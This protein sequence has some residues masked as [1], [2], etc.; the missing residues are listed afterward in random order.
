ME[1]LIKGAAYIIPLYVILVLVAAHRKKVDAY[2]I[3]VSGAGEGIA[4]AFKVMPYMA[5]MLFAIAML[6]ASGAADW[7]GGGADRLLHLLGVPE[8]I[9]LFLLLR[10]L[11]GSAALAELSEIYRIYG[12][13]SLQGRLA[14]VLMGSTET[15]FYTIPVYLGVTGIK[16]SRHAVLASLAAMLAGTLAAV[17]ICAVVF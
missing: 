10:P 4:S 9:S 7:L 17:L 2:G 5:G 12:A 13:D 6:R 8:G 1:W 14:S 16:D 15:I 3:F 11:S